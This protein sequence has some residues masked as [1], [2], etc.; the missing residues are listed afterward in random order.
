MKASELT[1]LQLRVVSALVM[2]AIVLTLTFM[3]GFAFRF[4]AAV[5][6]A[7]IFYEW[8]AMTPGG[9]RA[10]G[11]TIALAFIS[12][13]VFLLAGAGAFV[14]IIV[15]LV[16]GG[17]AALL[18]ETQQQGG[19]VATGFV[20]AAL[21][22]LALALLRGDT[23]AGLIAILFLFAVVWATDI[24]AY[25]VGRALGGPKLA[26]TISPGKTWSGAAGGLAGAI[27]GGLCL[28][29]VV[30]YATYGTFVVAVI[31]SVVSQL[32]DLFESAVKRTAGVKDS[33]HL[34]PGHG[35]VM[36]R[37]DGLVAGAMAL[38]LI[39]LLG[40]NFDNPAATLF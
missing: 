6:A 35:G 26:P 32:G 17:I 1:N 15:I 25:F 33:S 5:I 27:V 29:S 31:I 9:L 21:S 36:D 23:D 3:G 37:V 16:A 38:C 11:T 40:G 8:M 14:S 18:A 20:Y 13:L 4:L 34:I 24:C 22:G 7:G 28:A 30:G 19:W 10:Y 2:A 39:G 12:V